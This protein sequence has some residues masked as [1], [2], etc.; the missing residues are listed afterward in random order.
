MDIKALKI[1]T[2]RAELRKALSE[3]NS[4][5]SN[6]FNITREEYSVVRESIEEAIDR[7]S[8]HGEDVLELVRVLFRM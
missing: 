7:T 3:M 5:T 6:N 8:E 1:I 4:M 2:I